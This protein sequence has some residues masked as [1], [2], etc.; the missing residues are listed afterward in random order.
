MNLSKRET[1]NV[2]AKRL[3]NTDTGAKRITNPDTLK[4]VKVK[5][6]EFIHLLGESNLYVFI[7]CWGYI[8]WRKHHGVA[9]G[10]TKRTDR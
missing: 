3:E 6:G 1:L 10:S 9:Q 4:H 5:K 7:R 8:F 2:L